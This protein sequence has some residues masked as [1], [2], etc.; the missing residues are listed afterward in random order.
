[1]PVGP[2][3]LNAPHGLRA[4]YQKPR[5]TVPGEAIGALSMLVDLRSQDIVMQVLGNGYHLYPLRKAFSTSWAVCGSVLQARARWKKGLFF[6]FFPPKNKALTRK[7]CLEA[8]G[9][10][11][12]GRAKATDCSTS[13]QGVSSTLR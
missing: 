3:F 5:T 1:V 9:D 6:F 13:D 7:F 4:I 11:S 10:C 12:S 8:I 2:K